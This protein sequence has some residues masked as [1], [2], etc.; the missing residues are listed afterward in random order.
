MLPVCVGEREGVSEAVVEEEVERVREPVDDTEAEGVVE[1]VFELVGDTVTL[2]EVPALLVG[3]QSEALGQELPV[4]DTESVEV[5]EAQKV[6]VLQGEDV[7][8]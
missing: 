6:A 5:E 1:G 7:E 8:E 4:K 3:A 2:K